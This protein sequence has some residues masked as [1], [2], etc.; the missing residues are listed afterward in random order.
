MLAEQRQALASIPHGF[1]FEEI[2]IQAIPYD[3]ATFDGLIA[4]HMLY[5]VPDRA[6]AIAELR[7]VLKPGG[8]LYTATNGEKHLREI[9]ALMGL[10]GFQP[11]EW[12]GGFV[13]RGSYSLESAPDQLRAQFEQVEVRRY[14]DGIEVTDPE[15][16][17]DYIQS[18]P[19]QL[20]EE[21][22][23]ALN[24]FIQA[25]IHKTGNMTITKD[26]GVIVAQG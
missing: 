15:A 8:V 24:T 1:T 12:L 13:E 16:I 6:K 4:N 11:N 25:R 9:H 7:R 19:L 17:V 23:N 14:D 20:S 22:L 26:M 18:H 2:D 5:H 3:D 10:L 21:Q